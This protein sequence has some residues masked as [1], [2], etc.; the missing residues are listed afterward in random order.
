V[1]GGEVAVAT[2][3]VAIGA[4]VQGVVGFGLGLIAAPL[5][6]LL[7]PDLVPGP[8]LFVG[9]PLT[10]LVALKERA[11][12]DFHGIRWAIAGR[13]PGTVLGTVAVALLPDG[14]L[15]VLL[16]VVVLAAVVLSVGGWYVRPT[17]GTL[18]TAGMASGFMGTAT[19]IGGPPMAMVYQR[20]GGPELRG[21]LA[22]YFL[23]GAAFSLAA[24]AVGGEFG[25]RELSMGLVLL[26]GVVGGF[27]LSW[28]VARLLDRGYTRAAVLG[29]SALSAI[30]LILSEIG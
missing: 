29:C 26:P 18:V 2:A 14:P 5:L 24:L 12:L 3:V 6:A 8:L 4:C 28:L 19:S 16:G 17:T 30:V 9:V 11:A 15:V 7:D 22:G 10:V 27:S 13:V 25:G 20:H 1:S 23:F 21:T